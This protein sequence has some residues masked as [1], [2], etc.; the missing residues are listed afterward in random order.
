MGFIG[1]EDFAFGAFR[2]SVRDRTLSGPEGGI[3]LKSRAFD[4]LLTLIECRGEVAS[5]DQLMR[6]VWGDLVVEENNLHV[7]VAAIRRAF[8]PA[9]RYILTIPGRG[10]RFI[11]VLQDEGAAADP[12]RRQA[13]AT[14]LPARMTALVGRSEDLAAIADLLD[15]ARLVTLVGPSGVGKT[16]LAIEAARRLRPRFP[17][18]CW[19]AGLGSVT[20]PGLALRAVAASLRTDEIQ[21]LPLI[22]G[23][24]DLLGRGE[25]LLVLDGCERVAGAVGALIDRLMRRCPRLRILS[26][27][28]LPLGLEGERVRCVTPLTAVSEPPTLRLEPVR[29]FARPAEVA[30]ARLDAADLDIR[31]PTARRSLD[32][33]TA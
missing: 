29:S 13:P 24:A 14:N 19:W 31:R 20:D 12:E 9:N 30:D 18:G 1:N 11:G 8:G 26:T 28:H 25:V 15:R 3:T 16:K 5:K 27:S 4:V 7:Q 23:L 33:R 10:Y 22:D 21:G 32:S 17:A 6:R 2:L